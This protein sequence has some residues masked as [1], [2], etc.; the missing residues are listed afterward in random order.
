MRRANLPAKAALLI[1]YFERKRPPEERTR[2]EVTIPE[3]VER[4]EVIRALESR[5]AW[6]TVGSMP[7]GDL[8][9]NLA[10]LVHALWRL[11]R[12]SDAPYI[13]PVASRFPEHVLDW[14]AAVVGADVEHVAVP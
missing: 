10:S 5:F 1:R 12:A 4:E 14:H 9:A 7:D 6:F 8:I 11:L 3:N 13:A 2:W